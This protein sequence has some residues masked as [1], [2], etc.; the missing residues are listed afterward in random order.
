MGKCGTARGPGMF[1]SIMI[2]GADHAKV[3]IF[4][5]SH[6]PPHL[7]MSK[8][9]FGADTKNPFSISSIV[10]STW[11]LITEAAF[12][13]SYWPVTRLAETAVVA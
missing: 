8:S 11:N 10:D 12:R 2:H 9:S 3:N 1:K 4:L 5:L 6:P 13:T 7:I